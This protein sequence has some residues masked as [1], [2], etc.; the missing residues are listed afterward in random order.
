MPVVASVTWLSLGHRFSEK[1][2]TSFLSNLHKCPAPAFRLAP[3]RK[4]KRQLPVSMWKRTR[5]LLGGPTGLDGILTTCVKIVPWDVTSPWNIHRCRPI[6]LLQM[7]LQPRDCKRSLGQNHSV[8]LSFY[9]N[10]S[11]QLTH[12]SCRLVQG[13]STK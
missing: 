2:K 9:G 5:E 8:L 7:K 12:R 10:N 1:K 11:S 6:Q 13:A 4:K 3:G